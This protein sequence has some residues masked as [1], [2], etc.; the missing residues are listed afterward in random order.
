MLRVIVSGL[1]ATLT[2]LSAGCRDAGP[3][4]SVGRPETV[5]SQKQMNDAGVRGIDASIYGLAA[6]DDRNCKWF[7]TNR[8]KLVHTIGPKSNPFA[9]VVVNGGDIRGLPDP[10]KDTRLGFE[11]DRRWGNASWIANVYRDPKSGHILGFVHLEYHPQKRGEVYFRF[12]LAISKDGGKTFTWC[13]Y[14]IEPEL[15]Y[16]TWRDKWRRGGLK[17]GHHVFANMGLA[18]YVVRDGFFHLYYTDTR[19][20]PD[21]FSNG[22]A[23]ARAKVADVLSAADKLQTTPWKKYFNGKWDSPGMNGE[24]TALNVEPLGFLHGDAAYNSYL[25]QF[26]MVT[27]TGKVL[28]AGRPGRRSSIVISFSKDGIAW[29][30]WRTIHADNHLHDY[31]SIVSLG[32]DNEVTG[33]SFWVYYKYFYDSVL[34]KI[35]WGK[36]RWDRTLV[37]LE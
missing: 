9:R 36:N 12:G 10:Y 17:N 15:T 7:F 8:F 31:P 18:N 25:K 34:P 37:T 22:V 29:S 35:D 19:E 6:G 20:S 23:V 30:D 14:I 21:T 11:V 28:P 1:V 13:G 3:E 27:R 5:I 4:F 32:A 33:K 24:F 16:K 26:V 2:V